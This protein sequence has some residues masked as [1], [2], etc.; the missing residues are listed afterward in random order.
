MKLFK[1][2][3]RRKKPARPS[4]IVDYTAKRDAA[5]KHLGDEYLCA[6]PQR[7]RDTSR[8]G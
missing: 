8:W 2:L 3:F 5:L 1:K 6:K 7:R 4:L